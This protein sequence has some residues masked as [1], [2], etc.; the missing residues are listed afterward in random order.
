MVAGVGSLGWKILGGGGAVLAG[1]AARKALTTVWKT[2]TGNE[3]PTVPEDPDTE[4][5][6]AV[7]W[8]LASGA[9]VGLAR[10]FATR[11]AAGYYRRSTGKLPKALDRD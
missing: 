9:A 2:A 1:L 8:A 4:W 11:Q 7:L 3:P 10:L 5:H 6:E